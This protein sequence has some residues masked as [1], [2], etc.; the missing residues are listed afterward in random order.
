ML[1][2]SKLADYATVVMV[3][4]AKHPQSLKNAK[5]VAQDIHLAVPT[6]S[7]LLKLLAQADLLISQR[8]AKGGYQL[9]RPAEDIS[10]KN[11]IDAI[12]GNCGLTEC[13]YNE[14]E[15]ALESVCGLRDNW[16]I[17]S[18]A[19]NTALDTVR[20]S[21]LTRTRLQPTTVDVQTITH[22]HQDPRGEHG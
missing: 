9:A 19:I 22:M 14:G 16:R 18:Q 13:T 11:L 7:K 15:C 17:I 1:R 4:L 10:V 3:Y 2:L 21:D 8:G 12:E 5:Q 20:L 6:V